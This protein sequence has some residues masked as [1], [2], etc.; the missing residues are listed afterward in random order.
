MQ[1]VHSVPKKKAPVGAEEYGSCDG[2]VFCPS[3]DALSA[4]FRNSAGKVLLVSD[5][6]GCSLF[7]S[8][9]G[10]PRAISVVL[11]EDCLPLFSMP[12]VSR[13]L[14][15]GGKETLLAAR[16]FAQLM[17]I[18]CTVFPALA[19]LAGAVE[20]RESLL[21]S[22]EKI[23]VRIKKTCTVCDMQRLKATLDRAYG[24]L[25][26]ARLEQ[27]EGRALRAFGLKTDIEELDLADMLSPEELVK[28]LARIGGLKG[29]GAHLAQLLEYD[30][31]HNPEWQAFR[32]LTSL[33]AAFFE[34][35]RPRRY[36]TP[37]YKARAEAVEVPVSKRIP[38]AEEYTRRALALEGMRA[39][40]TTEIKALTAR[41]EEYLSALRSFS[42]QEE[43]EEEEDRLERLRYLP[44]YREG[45][46][47]AL[48]RDF[49]L[50][51]W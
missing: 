9:A 41:R 3:E 23:T 32:Q 31:V 2:L 24:R 27:F 25:L 10:S 12:E 43:A 21:V 17:H 19:T 18:P 36:Y 51:E 35:G 8:A 46:L 26:L 37:D 38:D 50:M 22:G 40:M 34:K 45:G 5:E 15:A 7:A 29:E 1:L 48:I 16:F 30:R 11:E 42:A 14:A 28:E 4:A 6:Y 33:Y 47:S 39:Q 20:E 49:G 13:V 44:E